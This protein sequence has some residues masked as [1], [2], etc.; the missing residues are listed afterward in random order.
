MTA[1]LLAIPILIGLSFW[2]YTRRKP[3]QE[4]HA[5]YWIYLPGEALPP[6]NAIMDRIIG[7]NPYRPGGR[8]AIG[9]AEGLLLSDIRL[10]MA[11]VRRERNPFCFRPDF[12][13]GRVEVTP[14]D[15]H[16]LKSAGCFIK[17]RYYA[18]AP[19]RARTH[20]QFL[21]HAADA[22]AELGQ[23]SL[24][25]DAIGERLWTRST[26]A[27]LLAREPDLTRSDTHL[28]V[29]WR[30]AGG[31]HAETRGLKKVGQLE[32]R[33]EVMADQDRVLVERALLEA[34][35]QLW[36]AAETPAEAAFDWYGDT[37]HVTFDR[38]REGWRPVRIMRE[39]RA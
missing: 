16:T 10:S 21:P 1:L 2:I 36:D 26:L 17:L 6:Q 23:G 15:A 25:Y 39:R 19:L 34:A 33:T 22:I 11:T 30:E 13:A 28:R 27:E 9:T 18:A 20:L 29:I 7:Q 35:T 8:P 38:P 3:T 37:L 5:E 32:L 12:F 24:I 4:L 31:L 14:E